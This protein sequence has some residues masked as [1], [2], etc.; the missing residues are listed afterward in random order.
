LDLWRGQQ[1]RPHGD[2]E[3]VVSS[4]ALRNVRECLPDHIFY[5]ASRG[6]L[7]EIGS[8]EPPDAHQFWVLD[9]VDSKW[10]LDVMVDPGDEHCW[11]YRRD[12]RIRA[13]RQEMLGRSQD[14]IPYL[15]PAA[16]L[17]FKAKNPR[18]KDEVDFLNVVGGLSRAERG[19]LQQALRIAHPS[20]S[21][22]PRLDFEQLS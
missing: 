4:S 9:P 6:V 1:S 21:W 8:A 3:I 22:I 16:V 7:R 15:R 10:R 14:G 12:V 13:S 17:L 2:I 5:A 19:W 18:P 20:S 11:V